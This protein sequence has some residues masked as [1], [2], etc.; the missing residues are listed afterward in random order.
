MG[1]DPPLRHDSYAFSESGWPF[2]AQAPADSTRQRSPSGSPF[3]RD[4]MSA[5]AIG[6]RPRL[7]V[8]TKRMEGIFDPVQR[9]LN[10]QTGSVIVSWL[11][12]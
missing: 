8:H 6:E 10:Y 5:M 12:R 3:R 11:R 4:R 1:F 2:G 9:K 7:A